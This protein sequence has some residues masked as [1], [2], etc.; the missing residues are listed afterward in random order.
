[1]SIATAFNGASYRLTRRE[2]RALAKDLFGV[3]VSLGS[4]QACCKSVSGAVVATA[5]VIYAEVKHAPEV[6]ADDP[7]LRNSFA[8]I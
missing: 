3:R 2:T 7:L 6:H 1:M 4:V 8:N 5:E